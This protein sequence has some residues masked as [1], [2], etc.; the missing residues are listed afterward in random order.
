MAQMQILR[1][2]NTNFIKIFKIIN[3]DMG[4]NKLS[5][6]ISFQLHFGGIYPNIPHRSNGQPLVF[7]YLWHL[8]FPF[9]I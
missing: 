9:G 1:H 7:F 4:V 6:K 8:I 3:L 5:E 2:N